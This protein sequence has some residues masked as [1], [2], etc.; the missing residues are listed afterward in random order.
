[1]RYGSYMQGTRTLD[2]FVS[3]LRRAHYNTADPI[4]DSKLR[5]TY[6][7]L[8]GYRRACGI[9]LMLGETCIAFRGR[10]GVIRN[11]LA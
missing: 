1:M 5:N 8:Q 10:G 7:T 9:E 6:S 4:H 2:E 11:P 3:G